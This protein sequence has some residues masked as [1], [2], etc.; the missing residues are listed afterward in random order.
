MPT[1]TT[2]ISSIEDILQDGAY[3]QE[4][5]TD[6]INLALQHIAGGIRMPN[7]ISPPLPDLYTYGTVNTST[8][9]P[10]VSLPS[11]YQRNVSLVYLEGN[12]KINPPRGGD[13]YAFRLFANQTHDKGFAETGTIYR[14]AVK[15]S[16]IYYQGIPTATT[17]IG[18]HYYKKPDTMALEGDSPEGLPEHLAEL[19]IKHYVLMNIFGEAIEDG[20]DNT[21]IGSKYHAGKFYT[22]MTDLCDYVGIDAE[23]EY[24]GA[25]GF[26]DAGRCD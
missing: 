22:Y 10:Y 19:L 6:R 12:Y 3:T 5:L 18:V 8:S 23:P 26:V 11:D 16:N 2:L 4:R 15:G 9:L 14:V 20:Q 21:G 17:T 1:L 25:G 7:Q 13:Y 24:Y